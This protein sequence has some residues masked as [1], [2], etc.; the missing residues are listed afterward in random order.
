MPRRHPH[1]KRKRR[2]HNAAR[3]RRVALSELRARKKS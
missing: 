1:A 2:R 3:V